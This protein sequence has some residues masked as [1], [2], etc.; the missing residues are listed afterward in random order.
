MAAAVGGYGEHEEA[1]E[2]GNEGRN[3]GSEI[4]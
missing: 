2:K 1:N 4:W 3:E